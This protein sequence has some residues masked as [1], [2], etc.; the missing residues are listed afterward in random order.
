MGTIEYPRISGS[1]CGEDGGNAEETAVART[2]AWARA[3]AMRQQEQWQEQGRCGRNSCK[4]D[5]EGDA[6]DEGNAA[7]MTGYCCNG[8]SEVD[9]NSGGKQEQRGYNNR[10]VLILSRLPPI[11]KQTKRIQR[12][13]RCFEGVYHLERVQMGHRRS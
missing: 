11:S 4:K 6:Q 8:S 2:A 13:P 10:K 7:T 12:R 3:G 5:S 9:S 1:G